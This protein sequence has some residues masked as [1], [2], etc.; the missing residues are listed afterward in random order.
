MKKRSILLAV[1][2]LA[3]GD[4]VSLGDHGTSSDPLSANESNE[5]S[6]EPGF[7]SADPDAGADAGSIP[8]GDIAYIEV[9]ETDI[10]RTIRVDA[11]C[12]VTDHTGLDAMGDPTRCADLFVTSVD[13][14]SYG[15]GY[16]CVPNTC[17]GTVRIHL[18]DGTDLVR[19][20]GADRCSV[21]VPSVLTHKWLY[22]VWYSAGGG[23]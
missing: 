19:D 1:F 5:G 12:R 13:P 23:T 2:F 21:A 8:V 6:T 4:R 11:S 10:S 15:C 14:T 9:D 22:A 16:S 7:A 3:C 18:N 20:L 17:T